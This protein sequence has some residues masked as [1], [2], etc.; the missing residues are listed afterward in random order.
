MKEEIQRAKDLGLNGLRIHIKAEIPRK[1]YW[2]D[3]LGLLIQED[4]PNFW[5]EPDSIA[6][7]NWEQV[8][9][10]EIARDY[11]HPSIFSWVLFNETWGL[12]SKDS[13][14]RRSYTK[15]TQDWVRDWYDK[16]KAYDP[17]RLVRP[18]PFG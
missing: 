4:I 7:A 10:E 8:A 15:E 6:K 2:A 16:T 12:F 13:T 17:T 5:G 1:L 18:N 11:N 14:G 3:K 9:Q